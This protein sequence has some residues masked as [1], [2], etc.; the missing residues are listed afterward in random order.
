MELLLTMDKII[1][2][3]KSICIYD[4]LGVT[5]SELLVLVS[6]DKGHSTLKGV[7][8][9]L[10]TDKGHTYRVLG[11]LLK[12]NMISKEGKLHRAEYFLQEEGANV[13]KK[14]QVIKEFIV[15]TDFGDIPRDLQSGVKDILKSYE[16]RLVN[17][18]FYT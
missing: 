11:S 2:V 18:Y 8:R 10:L 4:E 13:L 3:A 5:Y 1:K 12:K 17:K 15:K 16:E 14:A 6:I 9:F 7:C